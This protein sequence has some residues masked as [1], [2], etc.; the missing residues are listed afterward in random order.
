[1]LKNYSKYYSQD[2]G[3]ANSR[4]DVPFAYALEN[5]VLSHLKI[6]GYEVFSYGNNEDKEID[7]VA[8]KNKETIF[9][10]VAYEVVPN[11]YDKNGKVLTGNYHREIGNL[12]EL[13]NSNK[14]I[15][16]SYKNKTYTENDGIQVINLL[17]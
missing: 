3:L 6:N 2:I 15:V 8:K 1:M 16:I 11:E 17:E 10:Q 14:K 13:K 12:R 5:I 7:F 9:I 4:A